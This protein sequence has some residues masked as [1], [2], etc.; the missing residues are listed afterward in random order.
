VPR[1]RSAVA[2]LVLLA[3][4]VAVV[5]VAVGDRP[6]PAP[7]GQ[8]LTRESAALRVLHS[9]DSRRATAYATGSTTAL[10][11]LYVPGSRAGAADLRV[12]HAYRARALRVRGM[13]MQV[14]ALSVLGSRPGWRRV[15]VTDRLVGAVAV[16]ADRRVRLPQ[17]RASSRV[18][19][20]MRGGEGRWRVASVTDG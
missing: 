3:G 11:D 12:L 9:W 14:L 6:P 1:S 7:R 18:I 10:R 8:A 17:D 4:A 19:T 15:R 16:R 20:L 5:V 13:R 2:L